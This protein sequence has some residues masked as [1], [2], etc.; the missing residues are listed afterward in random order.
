MTRDSGHNN[1]INKEVY[2]EQFDRLLAALVT[3]RP[4]LV[5]RK[6]V[7]FHQDN[8]KPH[9]AKM[10]IDKIRGMGWEVIPHPPYSPDIAPSDYYLF[11]SLQHFLSGKKFDSRDVIHSAIGQFFVSKTPE[12]YRSGIEDLPNRWQMIIDKGGKYL[13]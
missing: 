10:T 1:T 6:G 4:A 8:A 7:V 13:D 12:F 11:R 5:N 9:K 2:C 3:K